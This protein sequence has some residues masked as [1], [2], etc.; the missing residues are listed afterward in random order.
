MV[1]LHARHIGISQKNL[2][3]AFSGPTMEGAAP[4][5]ETQYKQVMIMMVSCKNMSFRAA[6]QE[7]EIIAPARLSVFPVYRLR[8]F[9]CLVNAKHSG[10]SPA[11]PFV[12]CI[13][14]RA[15]TDFRLPA[16][17]SNT[18][19]STKS[20]NSGERSGAP[21]EAVMRSMPIRYHDGRSQPRP[22]SR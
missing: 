7:I 19:S 16:R 1:A 15:L 21:A 3:C 9:F 11:I 6:Y 4:R 18:V 22:V 17:P 12:R 10:K 14:Y 13:P 8:L 5:T 20:R 2:C